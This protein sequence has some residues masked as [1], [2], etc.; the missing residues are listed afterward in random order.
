M[1][2]MSMLAVCAA[3]I[4]CGGNGGTPTQPNNPPPPPTPQTFA[5]SG[6]V[7]ESGGS[8]AISEATVRFEDGSNAGRF[9]TTDGSGNYRIDNLQRGGFTV[10][11]S[12]NGY[13]SRSQGVDITADRTLNFSLEPSGPRTRF[14]A[15]QHRVGQD[16]AAGRYFS[17][18]ASGCYWERQ[19]G[20]GGTLSDILSN[21]FISFNA[22]QWIVDILPSDRA[23]ESDPEC[24]TWFNSPRHGMQTT[25]AGGVWLVGSQIAPGIYRATVQSGCYW[26]RL[27]GFTG[28]LSDIIANDFIS[29][30]GTRNID[31]RSGD[32]GF[33]TDGDCGTWTQSLMLTSAAD[34]GATTRSEIERNR[35]MAR[36]RWPRR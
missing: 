13:T 35:E 9:A 4:A 28:T 17:D 14:G 34:D 19:S 15:G 29:T 7:T 5:L 8:F 10:S 27:R 25:I 11:A 32:T 21:E 1:K 6:R 18:P 23:F 2:R 26:E 3:F 12:A 33:H 22:Q 30:A 24:G 31:I 20:F 16:I 36:Q